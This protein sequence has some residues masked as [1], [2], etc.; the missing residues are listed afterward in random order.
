MGVQAVVLRKAKIPLHIKR[1][2]NILRAT[3]I[4]S[5]RECER[6]RAR[7]WVQNHGYELTDFR[8]DDKSYFFTQ[9]KA[10][11]FTFLRS[12]EVNDLPEHKHSCS[13]Y[14]HKVILV[15]GEIDDG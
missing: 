6:E 7:A 8:E 4:K 10:D 14:P 13:C 15:I 5:Y 2:P 9:K 1:L 3:V 11:K 12:I